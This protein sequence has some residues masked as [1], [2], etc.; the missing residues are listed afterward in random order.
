MTTKKDFDIFSSREKF[1]LN[2]EP[3]ESKKKKTKEDF[4]KKSRG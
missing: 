1:D 4:K 3:K 2:D